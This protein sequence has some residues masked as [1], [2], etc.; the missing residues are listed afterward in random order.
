M[1]NV[2]EQELEQLQKLDKL[3][4][5][6]QTILKGR[7]FLLIGVFVLV[8]TLLLVFIAA[9]VTH[10]QTRYLARLTLCFHP[11]HSGKI[12]QYDEKYILQ[13]LNRHTT[14]DAFAEH[15]DNARDRRI[16]DNIVISTDRKHPHNFNIELSAATENGAVSGINDFAQV[17][18][19]EYVKERSRDL[20][21]WKKLLEDEKDGLFKQVQELSAQI[22]E[23]TIPLQMASPEKDYD[24]LRLR[25][26][27]LQAGASRTAYVIEN[28]NRRHKQLDAELAAVNPAVL[29]N[30]HEIKA[31]FQEI[32]QLDREIAAATELYTDENPRMIALLSRRSAAQKRLDDFLAS[33]QIKAAD[34][35]TI[36]L[37]EKLSGELKSLLAELEAKSAEKLVL[38]N[39]IAECSRRIKLY[40]EYQPK[41]QQLNQQRRNLQESMQRLD[42]SIAEINYM[43][44]MVG[45][46]MFINEAAQSA[47]GEVPFAKKN[48]AI[49]VFAAVAATAFGAALIVLFEFFFGTVADSR[50]L[51]LYEEFHYLGVL[52]AKEEMFGS[53]EREKIAFNTLLHKFRSMGHHVVFTAT[54]PGAEIIPEFFEFLEWSLAMSG[55]KMLV[56]NMVQAEE[57]DPAAGGDAGGEGET[58]DTMIVTFA[59]GKC[60]LPVSSKKFLISSEFELLKCDFQLLKEKYDYI[61][62]R[63][64]FPLR[65]SK[66]FLEQISSLCDAA[67][68]SVGA[69][70]TPR[71]HLRELLAL[72]I[73]IQL[74][75]MT[76]ISDSAVKNLE[77][78]LKLEAES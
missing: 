35:Q 46:D 73:K 6:I 77:H 32:E 45:E 4:K 61:F 14:R 30:Q 72:Q 78:D 55:E 52:P 31:F 65:R 10:S 12:G 19:Q 26:G 58:L 25:L 15:F 54:L 48:L 71:K 41:L 28:L 62:I 1:N 76:I 39:E 49:C 64:A 29:A 50:E 13:I 38:D 18:I 23:L 57:F 40:Q 27:E 66:L 16:A 53:E 36:R 67:L 9:R 60:Y 11:K 74:P 7:L 21:Q 75:V 5:L 69:G 68:F 59:G 22:A 2:S 24:R 70:K 34:P 47:V 8:L 42:E 17:C 37:A 56:M 43:L 51:M 33:K 63:H 20:E 44:L 3:R